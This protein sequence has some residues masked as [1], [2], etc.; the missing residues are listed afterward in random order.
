MN[1]TLRSIIFTGL[2]IIPFIPLY[3]ASGLFFP[4]ITGK[5]FAFRIIVEIIFALWAILALRDSTYRPKYSSIFGAFV[6]F[7]AVMGIATMFAENPYKSFWSNYE[8]M[9]GYVTLLHLF[10]YF[11]VLGAMLQT[12]VLWNRLF[13]TSLFASFLMVFYSFLQLSGKLA[14]NQGGVRVDGTLGNATY[15]A[16]Y[17]V[18]H[19]FIALIFITRKETDT[20]AKWLYS[21]LVVGQVVVLYHTAT[22][23][24]ILGLLGGL[25]ATALLVMFWGKET[26]RLRKFSIGM[27]VAIFCVVLGFIAIKNTDF[28]Q[29]SPVLQRFATIS[30]SENQTQ[31]RGYVWPMAISGFKERPLFGWGQE[32]FN[33]VFN[34]YYAPE[35]Y[36]KEPWFDRTH[37]V[38]LD[39]LIAGGLFG[40]LSYLSL[41]CLGLYAIWKQGDFSFVERALVTGLFLAYLFHNIFVFDNL[42]SYIFFMLFLAYLH[43]DVAKPFSLK[44]RNA[45]S[46]FSAN[47]ARVNNIMAPLIIIVGVFVVYAVNAKA[48]A[49]N[50]ELITALSL[51]ER[52][53]VGARAHFEAALSNHSFGDQEIREQLMQAVYNLR[54]K[55]EVDIKEKQAYFE[56]AK[57]EYEIMIT[58]A[59]NDARHRL[60]FGAMLEAYGD[61]NDAITQLTKA[62]ELS[63]SKQTILYE[64]ASSYENIGKTSEALPYLKKALD[65][66]PENPDARTMYAI[67]LIYAGD[68]AQ[69]K[70]VLKSSPD[71]VINIDDRLIQAYYQTK[72]FAEI[73]DIWEEKVKQNPTDARTRAGLGAAYYQAGNR[74]G[75]IASFTEAVK[76]ETNPVTSSQ[77]QKAVD[78]LRSGGNL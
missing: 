22:R 37:D 59:P 60:F 36:N 63:P 45:F 57:R 46:V 35:M 12:R 7:L 24:A 61:A 55:N 3:V 41:F 18:F 11:V 9:E 64:I 1:S 23:G 39:W 6:A 76:L 29:K 30:W 53:P 49:A 4:F 14:I 50:T 48:Y 77:Y 65:L 69:A 2:F 43:F 21:I 8:R 25:L 54:Y 26:P 33:Y 71:G 74:G 68:A 10:A 5:N 73:V 42:V 13:L 75:A 47:Q 70:E 16:I 56:L 58:E 34:K 78:T 52:N 40:F 19:I 44:T 66:A 51:V 17:L 15:L 27:V 32:N 38:F 28:V 72:H 20:I 67:G 31:S 62:L